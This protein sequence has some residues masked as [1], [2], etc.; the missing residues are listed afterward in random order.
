[1]LHSQGFSTLWVLVMCPNSQEVDGE[2]VKVRLAE[3][4][5]ECEWPLGGPPLAGFA[6]VF[7]Q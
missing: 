2:A 3:S 7:L 1:M 4:R 5:H 6:L